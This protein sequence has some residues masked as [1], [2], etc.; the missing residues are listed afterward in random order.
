MKILLAAPGTG[1][2]TKIKS[3]IDEDYK[4][5]T[6]ILV[7]SFTNATVNDLQEDFEDYKTVFCRTLHSYA[8]TIN[9]LPDNYILKDIEYKHLLKLSEKL[10][11]DILSLC[12]QLNCMTFEM[13]ITGTV[14]FINS[15]PAY[16]DEKIGVIDL[17]VIDEF[18]DFNET[19]RS[20]LT[21][22]YK[23]TNDIIILGDDDQSLYGF[24]DA[25]PAALIEIYNDEGNEKIKHEHNCYRCPDEVVDSCKVLIEHNTSRVDKPWNKIKRSGELQVIQGYTQNSVVKYAIERIKEIRTAEKPESILVL[26]S[27]KM[28]I[29]PLI[30]AL[31]GERI[32]FIDHLTANIGK[33][34]YYL[35]WWLR[36]IFGTRQLLDVLFLVCA[37]RLTTKINLIE[38]LKEYLR[39]KK[40]YNELLELILSYKPF[41]T[42]LAAYLTSTPELD[43]FMKAHSEFNKFIEFIN[44]DDVRNST[45]EIMKTLS[46]P[47]EFDSER[48]NLMTIH[49]S[50]GLQA[51]NIFILGL[52]EGLLP[53]RNDG[54]DNIESQRRVLYVG[55]SRSKQRLWLLSS[56]QW[57]TSDILS[58]KADKSQFKFNGRKIMTGKISSFVT[59]MNLKVSSV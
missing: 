14:N 55:M 28:A 57:A 17:L 8:L 15:N 12:E 53:N 35:L 49:R 1:K 5:A 43:I 56:V 18:Q 27:V 9:H 4:D 44:K 38:K 52:T 32:E 34:D 16:A 29:Y 30:P 58:S 24:K 59:E 7:L 11:I 6:N 3:I 54:T 50:K 36:A 31:E 41:Q 45:E 22:L 2:T 23:Y 20:L 47:K 10:G 39:E 40:N 48:V 21:L 42:D 33:K 25:D 46:E 51:D 13:M 37:N 26:S 19:E